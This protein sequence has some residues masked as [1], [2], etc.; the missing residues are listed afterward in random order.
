MTF[1]KKMGIYWKEYFF[2]NDSRR[3]NGKMVF[4]PVTDEQVF[5][6]KFSTKTCHMKTCHKKL[7]RL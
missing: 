3:K 6:D 4:K 2:D 5:Y 7:G 1:C